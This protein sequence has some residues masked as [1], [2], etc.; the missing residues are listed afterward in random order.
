MTWHKTLEIKNTLFC[1][2]KKL[3]THAL[4]ILSTELLIFT[5]RTKYSVLRKEL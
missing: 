3:E 2:E 5:F 1:W 4:P